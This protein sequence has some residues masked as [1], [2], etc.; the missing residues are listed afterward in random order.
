MTDELSN[1]TGAEQTGKPDAAATYHHDMVTTTD[2]VGAVFLGIIALI[3]L[4]ALLRSQARN[5]ELIAQLQ[6][7]S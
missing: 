5:R 7:H 6:H 3:L 1:P 2:T 4:I